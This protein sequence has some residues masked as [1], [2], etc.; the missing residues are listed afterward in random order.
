MRR[1]KH[2]SNDLH[3]GAIATHGDGV[4]AE[5]VSTYYIMS[6][7]RSVSPSMKQEN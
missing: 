5:R 7:N 3:L 6:G 2:T 4:R 1:N